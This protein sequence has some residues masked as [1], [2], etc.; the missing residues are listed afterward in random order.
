MRV[1]H[2]I[3]LLVF[4]VSV[5][6]AA[7]GIAGN[8][9]L[10]R[11]AGTYTPTSTTYPS[12]GTQT[13]I[14]GSF[15]LTINGTT[16]HALRVV[17]DEELING[18]SLGGVYFQ[19]VPVT[20]TGCRGKVITVV[21][22]DGYSRN[23]TAIYMCT[24]T[25]PPEWLKVIKHSGIEAG[26]YQ[27]GGTLYLVVREEH[28]AKEFLFML[29]NW[30]LKVD[31]SEDEGV[32]TVEYVGSEPLKVGNPLLPLTAGL[33]VSL[34]YENLS[35]NKVIRKSGMYI[36]NKSVE[37]P[38]YTFD[39]IRFN[40]RGLTLIRV[41]GLIL[42]K[43]PVKVMIPLGIPSTQAC[44]LPKT[45]VVTVTVT[46]TVTVKEAGTSASTSTGYCRFI[47]Q[48]EYPEPSRTEVS[49][50]ELDNE[51]IVSE[52]PLRVHIPASISEPNIPLTFENSGKSPILI[53]Y[54][55]ECEIVSYSEDDIH[56]R[57]LN[58]EA[59]YVVPTTTIP[60]LPTE[61]LKNQPADTSII[62]S[63]SVN[64]LMPG[65]RASLISLSIPTNIDQL[66]EL[67]EYWLDVKAK[68]FYWPVKEIYGI[69]T[70]IRPYLTNYIAI[71]LYSE[72]EAELQFK[73][74]AN[75]GTPGS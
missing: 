29:G 16:Y 14:N 19:E 28:L 11:S 69:D 42:G 47:K 4:A 63:G 45:S 74:H 23:L 38:P 57:P 51:T 10:N 50:L 13:Q 72:R 1:R 53:K 64:L 40:A 31:V 17:N 35:L 73:V 21:F 8:F 52:G 15:L 66:K 20:I 22:P 26:V 49:E 9:A 43:I 67:K 41:E 7:A 75:M 60:P 5:A 3:L 62:H 48:G 59:F 27:K 55:A 34:Q 46:R 65:G 56:W 61:C 24:S 70:N 2:Q 39:S 12:G 18:V 54:Y 58:Y 32:L 44:T 68:I 37:I 36:Y 30:S 25:P 6:A 71:S 33:S